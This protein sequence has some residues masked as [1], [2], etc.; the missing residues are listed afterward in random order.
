MLQSL[1]QGGNFVRRP[2]P[3]PSETRKVTLPVRYAGAGGYQAGR[4]AAQTELSHGLQGFS[5]RS[6]VEY[7]I[8]PLALRGG[9][10]YQMDRWHASS[11]VGFNFTRS[12]GIDLAAYQ[13][14]ANVERKQKVAL[15]LSLRLNR[16]ED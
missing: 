16:A 3:S 11:G 8:G 7:S 12:L 5:V 4:W 13:T 10:R 1:F 14:T 15:A 2:M 9:S 6:G